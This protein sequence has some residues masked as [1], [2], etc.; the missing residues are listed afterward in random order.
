M[1][2]TTLDRGAPL[3]GRRCVITGAS[4]GIGAGIAR[5]FAAA[6]AH[7]GLVARTTADL[8]RLAAELRRAGGEVAIATADVGVAAEVE[9]AAVALRA[10]LGPIDTV[11]NNAGIVLRK[12]T[13]EITDAEW[14]AMM[15][16]NLDGPFYVARAFA[17]DLRAARGRLINIA[18]IAGRQGTALLASYCA[19]KH[20][21]VGLTRALAEEW[22]GEVAVNAI[23][24]GSV[25]TDML[26]HGMPGAAPA[27]TVDDVAATALFLAA[28]AP[29]AM[30]GSCL[31]V[32]G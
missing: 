27:M 29:A 2:A 22:R 12:A 1:T 26:R 9:R 21:L 25:D 32:F 17:R 18:S 4:R 3:R 28:D 13:A 5:R 10:A 11:V 31:D 30:T 15:A 23:C 14:R 6:G 19:G 8:E 16:V 24:P 20:G 7:V